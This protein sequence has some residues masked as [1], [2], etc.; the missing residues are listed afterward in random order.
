MFLKVL[1]IAALLLAAFLLIR[2][3]LRR[4]R[5]ADLA[6]AT[7]PSPERRR[8]LRLLAYGFAGLLLGGGAFSYFRD[9]Q[10]RQEVIGVRV[11]NIYSG[12]GVGYQARRGD[13]GWRRFTTLDGRSITLADVERLEIEEP[14]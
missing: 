1:L 8:L 3:R 2:W 13:V 9:W 11:V 7:T 10:A 6:V 14:R 12:E 5:E 4:S